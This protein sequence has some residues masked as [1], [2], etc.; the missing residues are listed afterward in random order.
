VYKQIEQYYKDNYN[1]LVNYFKRRA[2]SHEAAEDIVQEAFTRALK[3]HKSFNPERQSIEKWFYSIANNA[4]NNY[5]QQERISGMSVE[6]EEKHEPTY[7]LCDY[8]SDLVKKVKGYLKTQE[9]L[10]KDI[11]E[12]NF[13]KGYN[14]REVGQILNQPR[15]T[16]QSIVYRFR[17]DILREFGDTT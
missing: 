4:F 12:L 8:S 15:T 3:Y 2:G 17:S 6:M 14:M 13:F 5:R 1:N 7:E 9:G 16:V 11:I 10:V